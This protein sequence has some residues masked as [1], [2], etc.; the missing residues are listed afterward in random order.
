LQNAGQ[1]DFVTSSASAQTA[2]LLANN[3]VNL[4]SGSIS[5]AANLSLNITAGSGISTSVI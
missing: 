4:S 1:I 3:I 5:S 2:N